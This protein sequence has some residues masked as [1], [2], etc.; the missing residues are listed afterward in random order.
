MAV[1]N[2]SFDRNDRR[3]LP[4]RP[5]KNS[6][7][8]DDIVREA[9]EFLQRKIKPSTYREPV[10]SRIYYEC[11]TPH[12]NATPIAVINIHIG[13]RDKIS[14]PPSDLL[15]GEFVIIHGHGMGKGCSAP[16]FCHQLGYRPTG[17]EHPSFLKAF[18][19]KWPQLELQQQ[20]FLVAGQGI[21]KHG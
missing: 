2:L 11:L 6:R 21:E 17:E 8:I 10:R 16:Y 20:L 14:Y 19:Q 7:N 4:D 5:E 13:E 18:Y 3:N 15:A 1:K 12:P 9:Q